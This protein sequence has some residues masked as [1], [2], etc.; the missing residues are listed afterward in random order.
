MR[1]N[2]V[3]GVSYVVLLVIGVVLS[4]TLLIGPSLLLITTICLMINLGYTLVK[5][6]RNIVRDE[7]VF[8]DSR[9]LL[10]T[11]AGVFGMFLIVSAFVGLGVLLF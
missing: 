11:V 8:G 6:S 1:V 10:G 7:T 4:F 9:F 2:Y 5:E 3:A